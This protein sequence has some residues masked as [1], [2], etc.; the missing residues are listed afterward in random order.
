MVTPPAGCTDILTTSCSFTGLTNGVTYTFSVAATNAQ[1]QGPAATAVATPAKLFA[2]SLSTNWSGYIDTAPN[3]ASDPTEMSGS[4]VVPTLNCT[5]V[6]QTQEKDTATWVGI[7]GTTKDTKKNNLFQTGTSDFCGGT[8]QYDYGWTELLPAAESPFLTFDNYGNPITNLSLLPLPGDHMTGTVFYNGTAWE[9][10][11]TDVEQN[12]M[13][14]FVVGQAPEL[15]DLS[16]NQVIITFPTSSGTPTSYNGGLAS[17]WIME[18]PSSGT[19][20]LPFPNYQ[21]VTFTGLE[22][23]AAQPVLADTDGV[24]LVNANGLLIS[25]PGSFDNV[26]NSFTCTYKPKGL[27]SG[28][29]AAALLPWGATSSPTPAPL[30]TPSIQNHSL[31]RTS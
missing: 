16:T 24:G 1:G 28:P 30:L 23:N 11:L 4:W 19:G 31:F 2:G 5:N 20:L 18:D 21:S 17:E 7:G 14:K 9:T 22:V 12:V 3:Q 6:G 15:I 13:G 27:L 8:V 10:D 25:A 29:F 26:A